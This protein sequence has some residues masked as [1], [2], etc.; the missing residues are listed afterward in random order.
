MTHFAIPEFETERQILRAPHIDAPNTASINVATA[1]GAQFDADA[2]AKANQPGSPFYDPDDCD[3]HVYRHHK[4][5]P[6]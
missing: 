3:V 6:S 1:L 2:T 4:G 5:A